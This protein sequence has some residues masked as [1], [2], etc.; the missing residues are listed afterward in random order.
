MVEATLARA[1]AGSAPDLAVYATGLGE[2]FAR[3]V[4]RLDAPEII[5]I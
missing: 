1:E 3:T 4:S 5:S 2:S